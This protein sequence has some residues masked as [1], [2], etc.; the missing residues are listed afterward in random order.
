MSELAFTLERIN[1]DLKLRT[2]TQEQLINKLK[3]IFTM[4]GLPLSDYHKIFFIYKEV[5]FIDT[6]PPRHNRFYNCLNLDE[7]MIKFVKKNLCKIIEK[8]STKSER[9]IK[10]L[11]FQYDEEWNIFIQEREHTL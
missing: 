3:S 9:E 7:C 10:K 2:L 11:N 4:M 6:R 5:L 8:F 1:R